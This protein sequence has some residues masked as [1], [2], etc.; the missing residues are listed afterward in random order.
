MRSLRISTFRSSI[1]G[2]KGLI[3]NLQIAAQKI[4]TKSAT[5]DLIRTPRRKAL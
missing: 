4:Y 5:L 2:E 1:I 3:A